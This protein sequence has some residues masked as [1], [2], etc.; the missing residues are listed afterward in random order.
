MVVFTSFLPHHALDT[1]QLALI[2]AAIAAG[3]KFFIPSEWAPDT[4]G[5]NGA[6]LMRIGRDTLPPSPGVAAKRVVHNYLLARSGEGKIAFAM[7]HAGNSL[8]GT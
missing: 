5:A 2:D 6:T 8:T 3:V 1:T 4:A 7:V